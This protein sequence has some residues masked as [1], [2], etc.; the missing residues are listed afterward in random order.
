MNSKSG[1]TL[2]ELLIVCTLLTIILAFSVP[3]FRSHILS[4]PLQEAARKVIGTIRT[5]R[6][7]AVSRVEGCFVRLETSE[8]KYGYHCPAPVDPEEQQIEQEKEWGRLVSLPADI[9]I[10]SVWHGQD[11][12]ATSGLVSAWVNRTGIM[13]RLIINLSDGE[14]EI[15][16]V[17]SVFLEEIMIEE[18]ALSPDDLALN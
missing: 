2:L 11:Q 13:D 9:E 15:S 4:D 5:A 3:A 12:A 16:I 14:K 8:H 10:T 18:K 7:E 6:Q 17:T 1:F